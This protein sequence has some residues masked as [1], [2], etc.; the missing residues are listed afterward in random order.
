MD[1]LTSLI[2]STYPMTDYAL[3]AA[4]T[5]CTDQLASLQAEKTAIQ[6]VMS[7]IYAGINPRIASQATTEG[8]R[9]SVV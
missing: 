8:D 6:S 7:Q 4:T 3:G 5:S 1:T 9:K 2:G